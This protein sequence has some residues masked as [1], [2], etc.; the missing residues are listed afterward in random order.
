MAQDKSHKHVAV[1]GAGILGSCTALFLARRGFHVDLIDMDTA[2]MNGASRWNEGK[3]HLGYLYGG[4]P[5]LATAHHLIE[6]GLAFAPLLQQLIEQPLAAHTTAADDIFLLHRDSFINADQAGH[7]YS[8]VDAAVR[9]NPLAASY[10]SD[11]SSAS[12]RPLGKAELANIAVDD[13]AQ[14]GFHVPERSV[15]TQWVADQLCAALAGESNIRLLLKR[16]VSSAQPL[17]SVNGRWR[18]TT[19]DSADSDT[20]NNVA[21]E[22]ADYDVV[23]NALWHGRIAVDQTAGLAPPGEW[24]NRY[25]VSLFVRTMGS[26][27]VPSAVL[28][29]GPYGDIKNYSGRD[30]YFSWYPAGLL[31]QSDNSPP[32][33]GFSTSHYEEVPV[34]RAMRSGLAGAFRG[35]DSIFDDAAEIRLAGGYVFAQGSGSLASPTATLHRR[36]RSGIERS[37][38]YISVDT[39]KSF[40][41]PWLAASIAREIAGD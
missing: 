29:V 10:L 17:D 27:Q 31:A 3:I 18:V 30:F 19:V 35:L 8:Q 6:G 40:V 7:Y 22:Q 14:A 2:P 20:V 28:A 25:R 16:Y 32:D 24:S 13:I 1:L 21:Q 36:D 4:D 9:S 34:I 38:N 23:V 33:M 11:S 12:S 37:G 5:T 41:A 39:G 15:Q 26:F